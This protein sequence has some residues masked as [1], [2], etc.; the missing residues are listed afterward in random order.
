MRRAED[1][2]R[3]SL[4]VCAVETSITQTYSKNRQE[5]VHGMDGHDCAE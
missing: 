4:V 2:E 5:P 3:E 1:K